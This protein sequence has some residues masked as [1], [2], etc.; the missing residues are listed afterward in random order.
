MNLTCVGFD[1]GYTLVHTHRE[2]IFQ[3]AI[4]ELGIYRDLP[5]IFEAYHLTDKL[6]MRDYPGVLCGRRSDFMP[7]YFRKLLEAL[8]IEANA[9]TV[10]TAFFAEEQVHEDTE[11]GMWFTY[12][13]TA[14][15]LSMLRGQ[16]IRTV[17]ISN[18]DETAE[19]VLKQNRLNGLLDEIV[20]SSKVGVS[21]PDQEIF[22]I[23]LSRIGAKPEC[24]LYVGDN[25]YDDFMGANKAGMHFVLI[26]HFGRIG[27]EEIRDIDVLSD[28]HDLPQYLEQH[29]NI[30]NEEKT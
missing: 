7:S 21:K 20:I 24:S 29:Y 8:S 19:R 9:K 10:L 11:K 17:L 28:I 2:M 14:G 1:L 16:G 3:K 22:E 18:W 13:S 6:F 15:V 25:Y 5:E 27:I 4:K 30:R 26:N 23:A 12:E